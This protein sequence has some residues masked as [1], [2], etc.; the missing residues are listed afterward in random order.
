MLFRSITESI[1]TTQECC[2]ANKGFPTIYSQVSN[3]TILNTGY[4]CCATNDSRSNCGCNVA[5]K[6]LPIFDPI[7]LPIGS[8]Q[9]DK[10]LEFIKEDGS[11]GIVTPDGSNCPGEGFYTVLTPNTTDP[12]TGEIGTACK[13]TQLGLQDLALGDYGKMYQHMYNKKLN[14]QELY[15]TIRY[16]AINPWILMKKNIP[17]DIYNDVYSKAK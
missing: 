11:L 17:V 12:Y 1:Y 5:C 2:K 7:L 10:Y 9:Q 16:R 15:E 6:W 3:G 4:V 8:T 13:L 14:A